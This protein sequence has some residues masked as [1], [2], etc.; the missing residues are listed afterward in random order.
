MSTETWEKPCTD[1]LW[2]ISQVKDPVRHAL[3]PSLTKDTGEK[4]SLA[5]AM[6]MELC[7]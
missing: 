2:T 4:F 5:D 1:I 3:V 7:G 6:D